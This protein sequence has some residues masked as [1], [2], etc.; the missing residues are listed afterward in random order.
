MILD[1]GRRF[2]AIFAI[3]EIGINHNGSLDIAR[4]LIDVTK[5]AGADAVKFQKRTINLVYSEEILDAPRESLRG[6]TQRQQKEGLEFGLEEYQEIDSY[7]R[8]KGIEWFASA[9]DLQSQKFLRKFDLK[10]NKVAS[11]MIVYDDLLKMTADEKS[12]R[13]YQPA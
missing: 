11:A 4:K 7:C 2:M 13:S 3:G 6:T 10:F 12:T 9:S 1:G 8:Y 5:D